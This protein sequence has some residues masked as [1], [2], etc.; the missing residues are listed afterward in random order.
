MPDPPVAEAPVAPWLGGSA[1]EGMPQYEAQLIECIE[2]GD[3]E[4][5]SHVAVAMELQGILPQLYTV[6]MLLTVIECVRGAPRS[7]MRLLPNRRGISE[8]G[9]GGRVAQ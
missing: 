3:P 1:S 8:D 5:A 7:R 9:S 4:G 6:K 2:A